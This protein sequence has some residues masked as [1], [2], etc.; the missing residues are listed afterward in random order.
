MS[1]R[2]RV[3]SS[4]R[5]QKPPS[6][7]SVTWSSRKAALPAETL[8]RSSPRGE[9]LHAQLLAF[10]VRACSARR[11]LCRAA[12]LFQHGDRVRLQLIQID[13][14]AGGAVQNTGAENAALRQIDEVLAAGHPRNADGVGQVVGGEFA[15]VLLFYPLADRAQ[16]DA[17]QALRQLLLSWPPGWRRS[18]LSTSACENS[19][20]ASSCDC[21]R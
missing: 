18:R 17:G 5:P 3:S 4:A 16:G 10:N 9:V 7:S 2:S 12:M 13:R 6:G 20:C 21:C 8:E 14:A 11:R 15:V 19:R 1:R